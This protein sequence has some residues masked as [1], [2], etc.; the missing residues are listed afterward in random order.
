M[1]N[2]VQCPL[3]RNAKWRYRP[4]ADFQVDRKRNLAFVLS[5]GHD[6]GGASVVTPT[7]ATRRHEGMESFGA[8]CLL[9]RADDE[10]VDLAPVARRQCFVEGP[11]GL[12]LL[13]LVDLS[14]RELRKFLLLVRGGSR[15][16][17]S[18]KGEDLQACLSHSP[19]GLEFRH[20]LDVD[21]APIRVWLARGEPDLVVVLVDAR[22]DAVNPA[23]AQRL[24]YG[25]RPSQRC[26]T[27]VSLDEADH[28][29]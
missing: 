15:P 22:A 16:G 3:S 8:R 19:G 23:K 25:L 14:G 12:V 21:R 2:V 24:V 1:V 20:A 10:P 28:Q 13:E 17:L 29:F 26:L 9:L 6:A 11:S 27:C 7:L 4:K 5:K 18:S